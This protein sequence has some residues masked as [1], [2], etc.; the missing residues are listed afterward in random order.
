MKMPLRVEDRPSRGRVYATM[1]EAVQDLGEESGQGPRRLSRWSHVASE[2]MVRKSLDGD[3]K[4][5]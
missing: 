1:M 4:R 3:M 5:A 2:A